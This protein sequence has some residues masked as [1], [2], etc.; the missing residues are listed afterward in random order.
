[1]GLL[2]LLFKKLFERE[3]IFKVIKPDDLI[4]LLQEGETLLN[5]LKKDTNLY[6][7]NK[8]PFIFEGTYTETTSVIFSV[9]KI[10]RLMELPCDLI[11]RKSVGTEDD[12]NLSKFIL[13]YLDEVTRSLEGIADIIH[14]FPIKQRVGFSQLNYWIERLERTLK[15]IKKLIN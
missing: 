2:R 15:N 11:K 8:D 6:N 5:I 3:K 4:P 12:K 13:S 9:K 7:K 14:F 10:A 1:M